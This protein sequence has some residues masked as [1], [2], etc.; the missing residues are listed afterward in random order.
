MA[1]VT[2]WAVL[3]AGGAAAVAQ[4]GGCLSVPRRGFV[5]VTSADTWEEGL[6]SGNG[7][8]GVNV[9]G[10]PLDETII[11]THARMYLPDGAPTPPPDTASRLGEMRR[12][13]EAGLYQTT[14]FPPPA[15]CLPIYK[16]F[17]LEPS[18]PIGP[19]GSR[20]TATCPLRSPR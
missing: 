12:L 15:P 20:K 3:L 19:A 17:G 7:T 14:S 18:G 9:L 11:F 13:I 8:I 16:V 4:A 1:H 10:R 6:L 2:F 5:S